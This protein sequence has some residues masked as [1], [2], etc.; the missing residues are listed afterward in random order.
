[1]RGEMITGDPECHKLNFDFLEV[2]RNDLEA[3]ETLEDL[4]RIL[5]EEAEPSR[6]KKKSSKY[7]GV[8][9]QPCGK[10]W[11]ATISVRHP[12][13]DTRIHTRT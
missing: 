11:D 7:R 8:M 13:C 9:G 5:K 1:M 3:V 12:S 4:K 2:E 10:T 6:L